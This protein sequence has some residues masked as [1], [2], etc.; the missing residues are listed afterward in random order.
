MGRFHLEI[1]IS[2]RT[3][4]YRKL[5]VTIWSG[6]YIKESKFTAPD[7]GHLILGFINYVPEVGVCL[8]S[9]LEEGG[10]RQH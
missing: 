2:I 4:F 3:T 7:G 6:P 1:N 9:F 5:I 10:T 8:F